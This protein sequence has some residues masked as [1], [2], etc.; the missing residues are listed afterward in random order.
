MGKFLTE[1]PLVTKHP[2]EFKEG[3]E[4][5]DWN[6]AYEALTIDKSVGIAT[7]F[8]PGTAE[9]LQAIERFIE[10]S[11]KNFSSL[12]NNPNIE[13]AASNLSPYMNFGQLSAQ[14]VVLRVKKSGKTDIGVFVEEAVVRRELA[15]N[16]CYY[17]PNYDN[18]DGCYGWAKITLEAH[19]AD[20]RAYVYTIKQLEEGK[21]HDVLWNAAQMQVVTRGK[22]HGF[23]RMYWAK[24]ILEWTKSP[25]DALEAAF[26]LNDH[27]Q[28]D[29]CDPNGVV[30]CMWSI[31]GTHDNAWAERPVF[32]K[33]RYMNYEGC[34]RKFDVD[35]FVLKYA[36]K[37]SMD[38]FVTKSEKAKS[39]KAKS[40]K[41]K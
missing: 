21:T 30:G 2:I 38:K 20:K 15:D 37:G 29:G 36:Q 40:S 22:M 6:T 16:F 8:T 10:K 32:G 35:K 3:V 14:R 5:V 33:I 11:L 41:A 17:Q 23:L 39:E 7:D 34:R 25:E 18:I 26:Y 28:L 12:R 1:F 9:G 19:K 27:Y 31:C 24:K 13:N 4:K